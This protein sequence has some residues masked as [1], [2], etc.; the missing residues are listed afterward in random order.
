MKV[1]FI[2]RHSGYVRNFESTLRMLCDRGHT[3]DL[4]FQIAGTHWLLDAGDTTQELCR[5]Y[6][7]FSR[8]TIPVREDAWGYVAREL[9]MNL[10]YLRYLTP[11]YRNAP[12]LVE[13]ATREVS[14]GLLQR[15]QRGLFRTP[16][17]RALLAGTMRAQLST[18]PS[19][20]RIDTFLDARRPDVLVVTP[21]IEPGAPQAEYIRSAS[22][23]GIRSALCVASWDN[24]T[25]KG[26]IH[27]SVGLVTVWN[28]MMKREAVELHRIAP[29]RVVVTGAQP[30]DHW[31]EW[32]ASSNHEEFCQQV[33][34]PADRPYV[35]YVCSSKFIAPEE[36]SFVRTWLQ[37]IR[38][39]TSPSLRRAGVLIRPHPQNADQW[40]E[41]NLGDEAAVVWP[42]A[43][44]A[45]SD[46]EGRAGYFDSIYHS[47]AVVGINTT[48]EIESAIIGRPVFTLLSPEFRDTQEGTLHFEHLRRVNG[49][50]L[51]IAA[52]FREHL[53]Q[54]D[55]AMR[56]P[57]AS[58]ERCRR[59]IEAFVRP[60]GIDQPATARL[61]DA[62][63]ALAQ[64][65]APAPV[66]TP[67]WAA[68]VRASL[69]RTGERLQR[70]AL[71]TAETKALKKA[72]KQRR[73]ETAAVAKETRAA[74]RTARALKPMRTWR[75]M[76]AAYRSLDWHQRLYFGR[77][78][79]DEVPGELV[80]SLLERVKPERLD[81][82]RADIYLRVTSK[83]ERNRLRACA[84]EPFTI[85]WIESAVR[86]GDVFY[87]I[88]ANIG[89]Y[90]LVA[91]KKPGGGARV[92][93][94]E[95][96]YTNLASL[97]ANIL[98][99]DVVEQITPVPVA[100]SNASELTV[101]RLRTLEP[102]GARHTL[103]HG[104]SAEG[105]TLYAQPAMTFGLDDLVERFGLPLPHHIKLDVDGSELAVLEGA[106]RTLASP[107]LRSLLIEVSTSMSNEVTQALEPLGLRLEA[108]EH[109]RNRAGECLVWYG[110]FTRE[111]A[112]GQEI[113]ETVREY[114]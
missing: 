7:Q 92:F 111:M 101:F 113:R 105:P 106:A 90:S 58:D 16:A 42:R 93:A 59:F 50:L 9:R 28:E 86:A 103:G 75:E 22:A 64:Q 108:R 52:S 63:E 83:T 112:K 97:C 37:E 36:V 114:V 25:N 95:P 60:Y 88:G 12:K 17:G 21:L 47:A 13:R 89:A 96:S 107:V 74:E 8:S 20:P 98:T 104:A 53:D 29:E 51:H 44:Q 49:G 61:V 43:G 110:L 48:A 79:A 85:D 40:A 15:T 34:L 27:G 77:V 68:L 33:G 102:G 2:M 55:A 94:F 91:A 65:P 24:L 39:S 41:V 31:F 70:E 30:F 4:A 67:R 99:N 10:D 23:L 81:Y 80:Q 69:H 100:L 87:D 76:A 46:A 38:Q 19:D 45:P 78:I 26:L 32:K 56:Q 109:V 54:L 71:L 66:R 82:P 18:I 84:K 5:Q 11:E 57:G 1:L 14:R 3:V 72:A 6:P 62:L 35:L 73:N